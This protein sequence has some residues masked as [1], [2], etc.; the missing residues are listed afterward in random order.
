MTHIQLLTTVGISFC[1]GYIL[2]F[3]SWMLFAIS[4]KRALNR[5]ENLVNLERSYTPSASP[6]EQSYNNWLNTPGTP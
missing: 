5:M 3:F 1:L 4:T 6:V 2:C